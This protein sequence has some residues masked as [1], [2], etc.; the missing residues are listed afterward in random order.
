MRSIHLVHKPEAIS[1]EDDSAVPQLILS[2]YSCFMAF[3][4]KIT[5]VLEG[6]SLLGPQPSESNL[7]F[8]EAS[9]SEAK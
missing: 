7:P 4:Y 6:S 8:H 3:I 5:I 1:S 9:A 2:Q